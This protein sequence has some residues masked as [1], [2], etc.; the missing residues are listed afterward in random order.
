MKLHL[1]KLN[2][3]SWRIKIFKLVLFS[4]NLYLNTGCVR[5]CHKQIWVLQSIEFSITELIGEMQNYKNEG[6]ASVILGIILHIF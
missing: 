6:Q 4:N 2:L 1:K 3:H 5:T